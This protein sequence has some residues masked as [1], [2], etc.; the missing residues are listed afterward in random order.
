MTFLIVVSSQYMHLEICKVVSFLVPIKF[1]MQLSALELVGKEKHWYAVEPYLFS[2]CH[3]LN[4]GIFF[5][6]NPTL[7]FV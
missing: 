2:L 1:S 3:G 5:V 4:N 6:W 7:A